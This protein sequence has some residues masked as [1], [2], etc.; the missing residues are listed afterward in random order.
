MMDIIVDGTTTTTLQLEIFFM[1]S[2]NQ[3]EN[4]LHPIAMIK[5]SRVSL[6]IILDGYKVYTFITVG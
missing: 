1:L 2:T 4:N 3:G 6:S 5:Q